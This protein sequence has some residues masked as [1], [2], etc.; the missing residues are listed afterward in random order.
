MKNPVHSAEVPEVIWSFWEDGFEAAPELVHL[1]VAT[2]RK[3]SGFR[4]VRLLNSENVFSYLDCHQLPKTFESLPVQMK[5]DAIRL[6][7]LAQYGGVWLDAST[8]VTGQLQTYTWRAKKSGGFFVFQNG[9]GGKGGRLFEIGVLVAAPRHPFL[10]AWSRSF[11]DFFSRKRTHFAHSPNGPAPLRVRI[12]FGVL[13]RHLRTSPSLSALWV[14]APLRWLRFYPYFVTYYLANRLIL[15][16]KFQTVLSQVEF[17]PARNYLWFRNEL[18]HGRG[19]AAAR[20]V[21]AKGIILSDVEFRVDVP[22]ENL[23]SITDILGL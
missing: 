13:N 4:D 9:E 5:S 6:A 1:C 15:Q 20:E 23:A 18:N 21:L 10:V 7:V 12:F 16:R 17:E 19:V 2:W 22:T 3:Y 11:N 8:L 14:R